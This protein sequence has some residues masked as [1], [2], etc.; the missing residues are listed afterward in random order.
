MYVPSDAASSAA[1]QVSP[2]ASS[3]RFT[4][5]PSSEA[6]K[7]VSIINFGVGLFRQ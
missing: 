2:A 5:S 6:S 7:S 4:A 3:S 1:S